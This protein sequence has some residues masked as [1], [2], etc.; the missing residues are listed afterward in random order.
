MS[1]TAPEPIR[2]FIVDDHPWIRM[3]LSEMLNAVGGFTVCGEAEAGA[4]ALELINE[5]RPD[6]AIVDISLKGGMDGIE[7]TGALKRQNPEVAVLVLSL[8]AELQY[9][10]RAFAAG[11]VGY[12]N[13]GEAPHL[14]AGALRSIMKG[15]TY[16]SPAMSGAR[17][18]GASG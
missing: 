5:I 6:I 11:A 18:G 17:V 2:I 1:D 16:L 7:L 3:G 13:K 10:T 15:E 14:L 4:Q 9:A 8:H 12:L